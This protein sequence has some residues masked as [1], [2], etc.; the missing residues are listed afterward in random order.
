MLAADGRRCVAAPAPL[1]ANAYWA[2]SS[3]ALA[4]A[5]S[6]HFELLRPALE[7]RGGLLPEHETYPKVEAFWKDAKVAWKEHWPAGSLADFVGRVGEHMPRCVRLDGH[8]RL[9][10]GIV[11][12]QFRFELDAL[13]RALVGSSPATGRECLAEDAVV[14]RIAGYEASMRAG[15]GAG[16]QKSDGIRIGIVEF[17]ADVG[18]GLIPCSE[19]ARMRTA[20]FSASASADRLPAGTLIRFCLSTVQK[21]RWVPESWSWCTFPQ[22][23]AT[24]MCELP[25]QDPRRL[26]WTQAGGGCAL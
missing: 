8:G 12:Q 1:I 15:K 13:W 22:L 17:Y 20:T 19:H 10:R 21:E 26:S 14:G 16:K 25:P 11:E 4:D 9:Q 2:A 6:H 18:P 5:A 3:Q 24:Q 7:R 23:R